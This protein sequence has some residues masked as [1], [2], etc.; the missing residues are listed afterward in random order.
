M[1]KE[2]KDKDEVIEQVVEALQIDDKEKA[3]E[4]VTKVRYW[5]VGDTGEIGEINDEF[6]ARQRE[7]M[8]NNFASNAWEAIHK[9]GVEVYT[10]V[11]QFFSDV[12]K[13][14][15]DMGT[16]VSKSISSFFENLSKTASRRAAG[17]TLGEIS[18]RGKEAMEDTN[19]TAYNVTKQRKENDVYRANSKVHKEIIGKGKDIVKGLRNVT[20]EEKKYSA[21]KAKDTPKGQSL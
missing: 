18:K 7:G 2:T 6:L 3:V 5:P 21:P 8:M 20:E 15:K 14:F 17:A 10:A 12:A 16:E 9:K 1:S 13:F 11:T 19:V 4:T